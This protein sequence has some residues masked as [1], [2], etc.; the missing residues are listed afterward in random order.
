M[1]GHVSTMPLEFQISVVS[2]SS[3]NLNAVSTR[4]VQEVFAVLPSLTIC[5]SFN[6]RPIQL[7]LLLYVCPRFHVSFTNVTGYAKNLSN[8]GLYKVEAK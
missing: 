7:V 1:H 6:S 2:V 4:L 5:I 8:I 3:R